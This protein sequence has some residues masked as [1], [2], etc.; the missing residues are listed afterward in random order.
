VKSRFQS[1]PFKRNLQR[2][3][4]ASDGIKAG[5]VQVEFSLPIACKHLVSSLKAPTWFQPSNLNLS[6]E[7]LV[8]NFCFQIRLGPLYFKVL[9]E[10]CERAAAVGLCTLNQVDP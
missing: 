6:S 5:A 8:S 2:Y 3:I 9:R 1:L 4:V 7:K 10:W